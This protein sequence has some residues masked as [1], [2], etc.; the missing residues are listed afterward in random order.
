MDNN[1]KLI[2]DLQ[3][4]LDAMRKENDL[5]AERQK[6]LEEEHKRLAENQ[7][8]LEAERKAIEEHNQRL[9]MENE[10]MNNTLGQ[11]RKEKSEGFDEMLS[12]KIFPYLDGLI[13][14]DEKISKAVETVKESFK[15]GAQGAFLD[16]ESQAIKPMLDVV[17]AA[18]SANSMKS[19]TFENLVQKQKQ[20]VEE[21]QKL[22]KDIEMMTSAH[23]EEKKGLLEL[24]EQ[25]E[26]EK[27]EFMKQIEELRS[28]TSTI[29]NVAEHFDKSVAENVVTA[30]ASSN[31]K[32]SGFGT[33]FD[34]NLSS[35]WR[36]SY[37]RDKEFY[38]N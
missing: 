6:A 2:N 30:T 15:T 34:S 5:K 12:S 36:S 3:R 27:E 24:K 32:P 31:D 17:Y 22:E 23:A 37:N 28:Q 20:V 1:T 25:L 29:K 19:S 8:R 21:K 10:S 13:K 35:N 33:L 18:A 14:E 7:Q 11:V 26:K 16:N 4:Q 9:Q 38:K